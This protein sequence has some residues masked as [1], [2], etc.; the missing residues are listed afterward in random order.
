MSDPPRAKP[1]MSTRGHRKIERSF[2]KVSEPISPQQL[3]R[4][5][6]ASSILHQEPHNVH[7]SSLPRDTTRKDLIQSLYSIAPIGR[8]LCIT[9]DGPGPRHPIHSVA[10]LELSTRKQAFAVYQAKKD[11][12]L[13]VKGCSPFVS[14]SLKKREIGIASGL[15]TVASHLRIKENMASRVLRISG[16][17]ADPMLNEKALRTLF[18]DNMSYPDEEKVYVAEAD[19]VTDIYWYFFCWRYQARPAVSL[20]F[21]HTNF[22]AY[23]APDPIAFAPDYEK[24]AMINKWIDKGVTQQHKEKKE[25]RDSI[26]YAPDGSVMASFIAELREK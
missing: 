19:G 22:R 5:P 15:G 26:V 20:V 1:P 3:Q 21:R 7:L 8:V 25:G 10:T 4:D 9:L 16:R 18:A 13:R 17:T 6:I 11:G 23:Y 24:M 14:I 12:T 2:R